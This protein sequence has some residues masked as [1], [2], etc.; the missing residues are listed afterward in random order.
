MSRLLFVTSNGTGLGHL[1]EN[2]SEPNFLK[3]LLGGIQTAAGAV[4][5]DCS[6]SQ[7]SS[8]EKVTLDDNT[9]NP[10]MVDVAKDAQ[11]LQ[12]TVTPRQSVRKTIF[13][14]KENAWLVGIVASGNV[15]RVELGFFEAAR[16][17]LI[18]TGNLLDLTW[19]S[20]VKLAQRMGHPAIAFTDHGV[21]QGYPEAMLATDEIHKTDPD[22]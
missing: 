15:R 4:N 10:M 22:F 11:V 6:A 18:Q 16:E 14:E 2:Y 21:C 20:I 19:K 13:G 3:L 7:S 1:K 9:S 8:F 17:G 5:A 12:V